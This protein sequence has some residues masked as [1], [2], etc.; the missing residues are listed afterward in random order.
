MT[1]SEPDR[2]LLTTAEPATWLRGVSA[3]I[4]AMTAVVPPVK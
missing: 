1:E 2:T 3:E 4:K